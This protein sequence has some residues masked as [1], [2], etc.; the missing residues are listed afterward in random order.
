MAGNSTRST[1]R[2]HAFFVRFPVDEWRQSTL[3]AGAFVAGVSVV[4]GL[5]ANRTFDVGDRFELLLRFGE[6][7]PQP[8]VLRLDRR[9]ALRDRRFLAALRPRVLRPQAAGF[10]AEHELLLDEL[11]VDRRE[12]LLQ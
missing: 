3:I 7:L 9:D 4:S 6:R 2:S 11:Q 10:V 1:P 12:R 8:A 5:L